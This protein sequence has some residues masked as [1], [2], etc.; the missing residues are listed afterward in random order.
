ML[1]AGSSHIANI[2]SVKIMD[3]SLILWVSVKDMGGQASITKHRFW[4]HKNPRHF[5]A[6]TGFGELKHF[7]PWN[8]AGF[9]WCQFGS[10]RSIRRS[11]FFRHH[12]HIQ[13]GPQVRAVRFYFGMWWKTMSY[14]GDLWCLISCQHNAKLS[15]FVGKIWRSASLIKCTFMILRMTLLFRQQ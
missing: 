15:E 8:T 2:S 4:F 5:W 10:P 3:Y 12:A 13:S 11:R 7:T 1:A 14:I 9:G 6:L